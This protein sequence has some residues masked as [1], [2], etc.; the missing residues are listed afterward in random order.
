MNRYC[1]VLTSRYYVTANDEDEAE[2]EAWN[3]KQDLEEF[4]VE[5]IM[6]L[7]EVQEE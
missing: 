7:G 2:T 3:N 1:V 6:D 4:V 5:E